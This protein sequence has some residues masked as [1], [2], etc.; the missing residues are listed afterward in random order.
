M[1][2]PARKIDI[3]QDFSGLT[4]EIPAPRHW[5]IILF[6]VVWL[7]AWVLAL[8]SL[9]DEL[10]QPEQVDGQLFSVLWLAIWTAGGLLVSHEVIWQITGLE[11]ITIRP[12]AITIARNTTV[13]TRKKRYE[14]SHVSD[15]RLV[16]SEP[17]FT[18]DRQKTFTAKGHLQFKYKRKKIAFGHGLSEPEARELLTKIKSDPRLPF[19]KS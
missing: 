12:E 5:F 19:G 13:W 8:D 15:L 1:H 3:R 7:C 6:F 4:I 17:L 10:S 9:I 11:V 18:L 16:E 2:K 14:M